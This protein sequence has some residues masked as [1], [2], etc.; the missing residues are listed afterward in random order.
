MDVVRAAKPRDQSLA[1]AF[2]HPKAR[3]ALANSYRHRDRSLLHRG[4]AL[5]GRWPTS[6]NHDP[7]RGDA[8]GKQLADRGGRLAPRHFADGVGWRRDTSDGARHR[9]IGSSSKDAF[10]YREC[11]R[12][13]AA[14]IPSKPHARRPRFRSVATDAENLTTCLKPCESSTVCAPLARHEG[15]G[16]T[17]PSLFCPRPL[18]GAFYDDL[19]VDENFPA[20]AT[21]VTG[22]PVISANLGLSSPGGNTRRG[23]ARDPRRRDQSFLGQRVSG[24]VGTSPSVSPRTRTLRPPRAFVAEWAPCEVGAVFAVRAIQKHD[25]RCGF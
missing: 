8:L 20:V 15:P 14:R 10:D 3:L 19:P 22:S 16:A 24:A 12:K 23:S 1:G 5:C 9:H 21:W 18:A 11:S 17:G 7:S 13:T 6:R 4:R 2:L 25:G